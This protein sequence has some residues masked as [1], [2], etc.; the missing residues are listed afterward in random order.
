MELKTSLEQ[1]VIVIP[2]YKQ[3]I[4]ELEAISLQQCFKKLNDYSICFATFKELNIDEYLNIYDRYCSK[5]VTI[6]FFN[7]TYFKSTNSYSKLLLTNLF[8]MQFV[9]YKYILIYQTDCFVFKDEIQKWIRKDY[10]YIGAPWFEGYDRNNNNFNFAGVGNGGFSLRKVKSFIKVLNTLSYITKPNVLFKTFFT[11]LNI[12]KL[13]IRFYRLVLNLTIKNNTFYLFNN[14][15][16]NED[17]FWSFVTK[18][19]FKWFKIAEENEAYKFCFEVN[20]EY[21]LK[22]N[23]N[24]LPFACHAWQKNNLP[25]WKPFIENEGFKLSS[26]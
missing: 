25:F 17:L 10:D 6:K 5:K 8:Y 19:N 12:W 13:P 3:S 2:I 18:N 9:Q 7:K 24:E 26:I 20:P 11:D 1:V 4:T 22:L 16:N 14:Y 23:H 21:L 15:S